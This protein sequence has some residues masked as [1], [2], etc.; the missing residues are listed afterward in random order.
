MSLR[1]LWAK[2]QL[3]RYVTVGATGTVYD[4]LLFIALVY[5]GTDKIIANSTSFVLATVLAFVGHKT[6]TFKHRKTNSRKSMLK[7]FTVNTSGLMLSNLIL[8]FTVD[9]LGFSI[10]S[11]KITAIVLT[12]AIL[13]LV[14]SLW[15]FSEE[16]L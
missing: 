15:S 13:Y 14:N 11:G 5:S 16:S 7:F 1:T 10:N 12:V 6:F 2:S 3:I 9:F 4:Y 8:L